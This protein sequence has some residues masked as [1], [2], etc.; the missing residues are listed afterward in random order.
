MNR[1]RSYCYSFL[2][3]EH[4][5]DLYT[6]GLS[7]NEIS[8][9]TGISCSYVSRLVR[10][11]LCTGCFSSLEIRPPHFYNREY[12]LSIL[13]EIEK[14]ALTLGEASIEYGI[15]QSSL[16]NWMNQYR[17]LGRLGFL[18]VGDHSLRKRYQTQNRMKKQNAGEKTPMSARERSLELEL[19]RAR[20]EI[21]YLKKLR[22]LVLKKEKQ[23]SLRKSKSSG[24]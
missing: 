18:S 5:V 17:A 21:A 9:L 3:K 6:K 20:T 19:E 13:Q 1:K 11:Y 7:V 14:K 8:V 12:K 2:E 23:E 10:V 22:A 16:Y 4:A 15:S 24:N